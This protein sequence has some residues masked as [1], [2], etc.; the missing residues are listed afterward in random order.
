MMKKMLKL[1]IV[2]VALCGLPAIAQNQNNTTCNNPATCTQSDCQN[3][4]QCTVNGKNKGQRPD[5]F[6]GI[7]LSDTQ[8]QALEQLQ[9]QCKAKNEARKQELNKDKQA[10]RQA[11]DAR[12]M[13]RKND[14]REYLN[15]VKGILSPE[16]YVV[17]LENIVIEKGAPNEVRKDMRFDRGRKG[18]KDN[19]HRGAKVNASMKQNA[20]K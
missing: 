6:A 15:S 10:R 5:P 20:N 14:R 2:A 11:A 1:A 16:Q 4:A 3:A 18:M 7:T 19:N 12:K 9:T 8:K 17:F 13:D